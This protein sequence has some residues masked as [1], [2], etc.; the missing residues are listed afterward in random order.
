MRAR[1]LGT[2]MLAGVLMLSTAAPATALLSSTD[3]LL[4]TTDTV[5]GELESLDALVDA[6]V[7]DLG[8]SPLDDTLVDTLLRTSSAGDDLDDPFGYGWTAHLPAYPDPDHVPSVYNDCPPGHNQCVD[9]VI[10]EMKRR[11]DKLGCD[12]AA[13][14][15]LTY[16]LTTEEYRRAVEDPDYFE[17]NAFV[18]HQDLVFAD[19]YFRPMDDWFKFERLER[20]PPAWRIAFHTGD[21]KEASTT[22]D[23]LLGMNAHIRRDLPFVLEAIGLV[24]PDG[25]TRKSDH[26]RVNDFLAKVQPT[27]SAELQRRHDPNFG[28]SSLPHSLDEH[29]TMHAI[30]LLREEAWRKAE[31]LAAAETEADRERVASLIEN[32]AAASALAIRALFAGDD[33]QIRHDHCTAWR[34]HG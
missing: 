3:T 8:V 29:A 31:L 2:G 12:H 6:V 27:I 28:G 19:F 5:L 4:S 32:D 23:L 1:L 7:E 14:F 17:D 11:Y 24:K 30:R 16:K 33:A 20:V 15:S 22:G 13:I 9:Q 21:Q 18:N 10:R 34:E 26:D 25:T